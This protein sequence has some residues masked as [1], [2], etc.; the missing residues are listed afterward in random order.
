M[1]LAAPAARRFVERP[2]PAMRGAL[3]YGPNRAL[4]NDA[5]NA[6]ARFALAGSD[7]PFATIKLTDEDLRK[8]KARLADALAGQPLLG[9]PTLVWAKLETEAGADTV[10]A[11]LAD[12]EGGAPGGYLLIEGGDF[13][14]SGKMAKAFDAAKRAVCAA[15]Y[16]E[17]DAERHAFARGLLQEMGVMLDRGAEETLFAL[18]PH[19]RG[20]ARR[21]IEKLALYANG[22]ALGIDAL[23]A[24]L[25]DESEA[26]LDEAALAALAGKANDSVEALTRVEG[27]NGVAAIKSLER[28]LMRLLEA[29]TQIDAGAS[30]QDAMGKLRPP[31]FWKE[32]D[33]FLAQTRTWNVRRLMAALDLAW[34][35]EARAKQGGAPQDLIAADMHRAVAILIAR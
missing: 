16:E 6:I 20:L 1:K 24:L 21:D 14:G 27:L 13:S 5:A 7:D 12:I 29:R 33:I 10:I 32:R 17:S 23:E 15:F 18:L 9:G 25:V 22:D 28:R 35:A 19:D 31:V 30:P 4:V 3:F 11:A 26:A 34:A 8:D 2:D